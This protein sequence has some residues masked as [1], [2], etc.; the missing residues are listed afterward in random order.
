[1]SMLRN[2]I[3]IIG[4]CMLG[5]TCP[6]P[7]PTPISIPPT[8]PITIS[9]SSLYWTIPTAN[10]DGSPLVDLGGF[11]VYAGTTSG[12]YG[13]VLDIVNPTAD[14]VALYTFLTLSGTYYL[15]VSAYDTLRLEGNKSQEI[16]IVA[17]P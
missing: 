9:K 11:K 4:L 5:A 6:G 16:K 14:F 15:A 17:Q 10:T 3:I 13:T 1:M 2:M 7:T 12:V 8:T